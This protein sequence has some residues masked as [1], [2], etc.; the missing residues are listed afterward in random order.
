MSIDRQILYDKVV[1]TLNKYADRKNSEG[2]RYSKALDYDLLMFLAREIIFHDPVG[3][4]FV[5]GD[6]SE[7]EGLPPDKS[8]FTTPEGCGLP[9]GNLTSQLFSNVYLNDF[10]QYVKRELKVKHYGRYVDD[11]F[12]IHESKEHLVYLIDKIRLYLQDTLHIKLHPKKI[13]LQH[14]RHGVP[15]LGVV[16]KPHRI[17]VSRRTIANFKQAMFRGDQYYKEHLEELRSVMNSYLGLTRHYRTFRLRKGIIDR[18]RW[19]FN[20]GW[21]DVRYR[22]FRLETLESD[23]GSR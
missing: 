9:I 13:Y 6:M 21:L 18:C 11:F 7:W 10:D 17:Y 20:Y 23:R 19:I 1:A 8:L 16:V 5:R 14:I 15:F 2:V 4:C 22:K 3:N 12:L